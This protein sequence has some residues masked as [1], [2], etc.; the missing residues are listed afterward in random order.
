MPTDGKGNTVQDAARS[1]AAQF[2]IEYRESR[3]IVWAF[4]PSLGGSAC[5]VLASDPSICCA[6]YSVYKNERLVERPEFAASEISIVDGI[7]FHNQ[8]AMPCFTA[9]LATAIRER[10]EARAELAKLEAAHNDL[11]IDRDDKHWQR[12]EAVKALQRLSNAYEEWNKP[13]SDADQEGHALS[14]A[15][16]D[17]ATLLSRIDTTEPNPLRVELD[18]LV[19]AC[20]ELCVMRVHG[21][22]ADLDEA[23]EAIEKVLTRLQGGAS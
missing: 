15:A 23:I 5:G 12:D 16:D 8:Y 6:S 18:E 10:D 7:H 21:N 4:I 1:T 14:E 11:K 3:E 2:T 17:A 13:Y 19:K 20:K 22:G 9:N